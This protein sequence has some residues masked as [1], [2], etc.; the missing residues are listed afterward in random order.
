M[1]EFIIEKGIVIDD[2]YCVLSELRKLSGKYIEDLGI[3]KKF[4]ASEDYTKFYFDSRMK[5]S[6]MPSGS[7]VYLWLDTGFT[8][9]KGKPIFVSLLQGFGGYVGHITGTPYTLANSAKGYFKQNR[10]TIDKNMQNFMNKYNAKSS[11]R[12]ISHIEDVKEYILDSCNRI[13]YES[14]ISRKLSSLGIT[15]EEEPE[16]VL[17]VEEVNED[18]LAEYRMSKLEENITIGLLLEKMDSMEK[19][20]EELLGVIE[21]ME[22]Q[23]QAEISELREKNEEYK[24][25]MV[26]MRTFMQEEDAE[27]TARREDDNIS[28]HS[29]LG[30]HNKILVIGGEELG[31]NVMHGIAKTYGFEKRDFEFVEYDKAKDYTDRIRRDGRYSAVIFGACPHKTASSNGYSS[32]VEKFRQIEGMPYTLDARTKSG[33]LKLTRESFRNALLGIY[34]YLKNVA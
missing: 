18:P 33:E 3:I 9:Y 25:A 21:K 8:D 34:D 22:I 20:M 19:Y 32:A 15:F 27:L 29:L 28:G 11:A 26:Q 24:R 14:D 12:K 13:E 1:S 7:D 17:V 31:V 30:V 16:T 4:I 5:S 6:T 23:D 10:I 2:E